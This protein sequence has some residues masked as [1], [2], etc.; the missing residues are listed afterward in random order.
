VLSV[1][2]KAFVAALLAAVIRVD[3]AQARQPSSGAL[4]LSEIRPAETS[5]ASPAE[6]ALLNAALLAPTAHSTALRPLS[7]AEIAAILAARPTGSDVHPSQL[8]VSRPLIQ[9][10]YN[11]SRPN[12]DI[13]GAV[14][15][16]RGISLAISGG[17][18]Y[19]W[20]FLDVAVR[21]VAF[22]TQNIAFTP[23]A[24]AGDSSFLPRHISGGIDLPY[25]FGSGSYGTID[26]GESF[27]RLG[28]SQFAVGASSASQVWGPGTFYPL[29]LGAEGPGI[30]R[31][32][33]ELRDVNVGAGRVGGQWIVGRLEASPFSELPPGRRSRFVSGATASFSPAPLPGLEI[34]ATRFFHVRWT[35]DV[36]VW[37]TALLPFKGLLKTG[38][39]T[40]E[41]FFRDHNQLASVFMRVAPPGGSVDVYGEFYREDHNI[42]NR[43]LA[44]EPDH[45][46]GYMLGLRT[47]WGDSSK[48]SAFTLE[49]TNGGISHLV[50]VRTQAEMY[51]HTPVAEG[52]TN[53]GQLL[54]SSAALGGGGVRAE[55]A[56]LYGTEAWTF[57]AEI[58]R[59][60][61]NME[62]GNYNGRPTG[63]YSVTVERVGSVEHALLSTR[64]TLENGFGWQAGLGMR[65]GVSL[66]GVPR[67]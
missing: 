53:R 35:P 67:L 7:S 19:Q 55:L 1:P 10:W 5:A 40:G 31:V 27:V 28:V 50:R 36:L 25:R 11:S 20:R 16:G 45:A 37:S 57:G 39:P 15:Q 48:I 66:R 60:A 13:D 2:R 18:T 64:M 12:V 22:M 65:L 46:S 41:T 33:A 54:G 44:G 23:L 63:A 29:V 24:P 9:V 3:V 6:R 38:N 42:N 17:L 51:V 30:P 49:L 14:W 58:R 56:R 43:D 47:A 21:P 4:P 52:H 8:A 59:T 62:G 32:F 26:P 61:H 34:G